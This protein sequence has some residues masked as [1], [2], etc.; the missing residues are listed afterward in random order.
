MDDIQPLVKQFVTTAFAL[1]VSSQNQEQIFEMLRP[2]LSGPPAVQ[3]HFKHSL[4]VGLLAAKIADFCHHH[5]RSLFIA[6]TL[7][8]VG[9][10]QIPYE[11]LGKT[12][13]WTSADTDVMQQHV[14]A[15]YNLIRDHFDFSAEIML[16]HH[17]FQRN[18]YPTSVP[19]HLHEYTARTIVLI[20]EYGRLLA[21]A[22]SYD[23]FHRPNGK[24]AGV[25]DG[26]RIKELMLEHNLDRTLLI[27][28][29]YHVGIFIA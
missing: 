6:G 5:G 4:R 22:D 16:W 13:N 23:A 25:I 9:K 1:D 11:V 12:T 24:Y 26:K 27:E 18:A 3:D 7:H 8:D 2:L 20:H 15:G 14:I 19:S 21:L 17:R 10:C 28:R 29:L